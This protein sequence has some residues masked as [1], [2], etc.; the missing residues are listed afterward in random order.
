M[1]AAAG[2]GDGEG[3]ESGAEAYVCATH[4][5]LRGVD[6]SS[7]QGA[8]NWS[9]VRAAGI[10]FAFA[11]SSEGTGLVDPYF[12]RNWAG[13]RAAG[14]VRGAYH[15]F[16]PGVSAEA[17]AQLV[18]ATV[19][20]L[21]A[22]DLPIVLDFEARDGIA[23]AT[24][25]ARAVTFLQIIANRTGR[26]PIVYMSAGFLSRSY[27]ALAPFPLWVAHYG[28]SCPSVPAGRTTWDFWQTSERGR[29]NG[30]PGGDVD[31]DVFN[32]SL[33]ELFV[34]LGDEPD[35]GAPTP[36]AGSADAGSADAGSTDAGSS[37]AGTGD[38]GTPPPPMDAGT[39]SPTDCVLAGRSYANNT[40]TETLQCARGTWGPRAFNPMACASG[41]LAGGACVTDRGVL[42]PMNTCTATLQ[43][44]NGVWGYR[45]DNP[46]RC[47]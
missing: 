19:G 45:A 24:A 7:Y 43:C 15:F 33:D 44:D 35:A 1:V 18:L 39:T 14:I 16:H 32:G 27:P 5:T 30:I 28:V 40:C 42:V 34:F 37:D 38:A 4:A 22:H 46:M 23:E 41:I 29:V 47:R 26:T 3:V 36:D 10:T 13:M 21:D 11:K 8:I 9:T 31:L 25:V 2:C 12:A 17:Q 20:P 6:V